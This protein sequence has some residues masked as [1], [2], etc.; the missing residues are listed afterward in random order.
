MKKIALLVVVMVV[1]LLIGMRGTASAVIAEDEVGLLKTL[2]AQLEQSARAEVDK[3]Q[4]L[5]RTGRYNEDILVTQLSAFL[6]ASQK[7]NAQLAST[8]DP[9]TSEI[10][11]VMNLLKTLVVNTDDVFVYDGGYDHVRRDWN[12]CKRILRRIDGLVYRQGFLRRVQSIV[13]SNKF[14]KD[15]GYFF[16]VNG[17]LGKIEDKMHG[18]KMFK[19]VN[20]IVGRHGGGRNTTKVMMVPEPTF[21][22]QATQNS[23]SAFNEDLQGF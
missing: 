7:L 17:L 6:D 20:D 4:A 19:P 2:A 16:Q 8:S 22:T 13:D 10:T 12:E 1:S 3:V 14:F 18:D 23:R 21:R 11:P 5:S 9:T 15:V